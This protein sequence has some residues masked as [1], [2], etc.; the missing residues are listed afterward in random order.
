MIGSIR[1]LHFYRPSFLLTMDAFLLISGFSSKTPTCSLPCPHL[2]FQDSAFDEQQMRES[3][4][5]IFTTYL[6]AHLAPPDGLKPQQCGDEREIDEENE[7]D[8]RTKFKNQLTVI[9]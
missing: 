1:S 4:L 5:Q 6:R 3:V 7:E 9:G 8:D 2:A